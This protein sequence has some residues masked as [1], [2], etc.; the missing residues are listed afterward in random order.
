MSA[1]GTQGAIYSCDKLVL[2]LKAAGRDAHRILNW[3]ALH[4]LLQY[5]HW[6]S[7]KLGTYREQYTIACENGGSFWL[8]VGLNTAGKLA[9]KDLRIE[10][11]PNKVANDPA[12][13]D[14]WRW[15][16]LN[17]AGRLRLIRWDLAVDYPIAR[18]RCTLIKDRRMY[19]ELR[20]SETDRTQ[21]VGQRNKAGRCK[22]YNKQLEQGLDAPMTRL[23]LTLDMEN[24]TDIAAAALWPTVY[25][26][27]NGA[28]IT[29][30]LNDTDRF[31]LRT[32]IECP[33]RL[34]ELGRKK[35]EKLEPM[36]AAARQKL[37]FDS[38]AFNAVLQQI[39]TF[40]WGNTLAE[41][42]EFTPMLGMEYPEIER[43]EQQWQ[44]DEMSL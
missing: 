35:R 8:G 24:S 23:E 41:P 6:T 22:L 18:E 15:L 25:V 12:F 38:T 21:Y 39:S 32:L 4:K 7:Y 5:Q 31:I 30:G 26:A 14:V 16:T 11:N 28:A 37:T 2:G 40:M 9:V 33:D 17:T 29:D 1:E 42:W 19:E 27:P 36:L 3:F 43:T 13:M 10:F 20:H 34:C 44:Q